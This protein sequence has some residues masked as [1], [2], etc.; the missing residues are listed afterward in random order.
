MGTST[1][2]SD[3][4]RQ[5]AA[6]LHSLLLLG[7]ALSLTC[8]TASVNG[9]ESGVVALRGGGGSG[10][11]HREHAHSS[12]RLQSSTC[13]GCA[14]DMC[15]PQSGCAGCDL[16]NGWLANGSGGCT[17]SVAV[18][19]GDRTA[20]NTAASDDDAAPDDNTAETLEYTNRALTF[21][22]LC[23]SNGV[24]ARGKTGSVFGTG[25]T[26]HLVKVVL[27][28]EAQVIAQ[29]GGVV[30]KA[31][32]WLARLGSLEAATGL[33]LTA[34][35]EMSNGTLV[36][37]TIAYNMAV[38]ELWLASGQSNMFFSLGDINSKD[39]ALYGQLARSAMAQAER[40]PDIRL[41]KVP[42]KMIPTPRIELQDATVWHL[43]TPD[44]VKAFSA[45]AYLTAVE[46]YKK[47]GVPIGIVQ[48]SYGG[49]SV[50]QWMPPAVLA[51]IKKPTTSRDS[52]TKNL[53]N[54]MIAPLKGTTWSGVMWYQGETDGGTTFDNPLYAFY[55]QMLRGIMT[56]WR[57]TFS[58]RDLEFQ[59]VQLARWLPPY[60][61]STKLSLNHWPLVRESQRMVI[62]ADDYSSMTSVVDL[63]LA[64]TIH[65]PNK[66]GVARRLAASI[67]ARG[68]QLA[69]VPVTVAASGPTFS[70]VRY[71]SKGTATITYSNTAG[72]LIVGYKD[73]YSVA[74]IKRQ[75]YYAAVRC[76]EV[77]YWGVW[78]GAIG[79]RTSSTQVTVT[80]RDKKIKKPSGVRYAWLDLPACNLY[81][82]AL[83]PAV[84]FTSDSY[85][86]INERSKMAAKTSG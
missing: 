66:F 37:Q 36:A 45:T 49:S 83:L 41:L 3:S 19:A 48:A 61:S 12:R 81:N 43:P 72:G 84:P 7:V 78:Y 79:R 57:S 53:Y 18:A 34:Q 58:Q 16:D 46:L 39:K 50:V 6:V 25:V 69:G 52:P 23:R 82:T 9:G 47:L 35:V 86:A 55:S 30:D 60:S 70:S 71:G 4:G 17:K 27:S 15:L 28:R 51:S 77:R 62:A 13:T 21:H 74:S 54:G 44:Y 64:A 38:G 8:A 76:F 10:I 68:Q 80:A 65:P 11:L 14:P 67:V 5:T 40:Y 33:T 1:Y 31:G 29:G 59:V 75:K 24:L 32:R 20:L 22:Q 73:N 85:Y 26:G 42:G 56:S 2:V 63:G